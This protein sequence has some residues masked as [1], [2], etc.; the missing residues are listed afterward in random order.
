M[1]MV[2]GG[3]K[4]DTLPHIPNHSR[5]PLRIHVGGMS[6]GIWTSHVILLIEGQQLIRINFEQKSMMCE[7]ECPFKFNVEGHLGTIVECL[8]GY[9][10][11]EKTM[12]NMEF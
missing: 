2:H 5:F 7:S 10:Y 12:I 8:Q 4:V 3:I 6:S 1:G 9:I 11:M